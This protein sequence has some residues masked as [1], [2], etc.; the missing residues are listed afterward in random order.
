M[1]TESSQSSYRQ[2]LKATSIFG[3]VQVFNVIIGIIKSK[4]VA[5]LIGP[6]GMGIYGLYISTVDLIF[7]LTN[8]GLGVSAV[9]NVS[10]ANS[11]EDETKISKII[12]VLKRWIWLTGLVGTL[13]T[14]IFSKQISIFTFGNADFSLPICWLSSVFILKSL[15]SGQLAILQGMRKIEY[16]AKSS[17]LG[18]FIGLLITIPV[19]YYFGLKG[20]VPTI[21]FTAITSLL[22]TWYYSTK[23][24]ISK[25]K[26]SF[27]ETL[28]LGKEMISLGIVLSISGFITMG[29]AYF[30][31]IFIG[32]KGGIED[33]GLFQAGF[34][35]VD[36][37]VGMVFTAIAMD[38]YPQLTAVSADRTK[39][40]E[41]IDKQAT[42]TILI[43]APIVTLFLIFIPVIIKILLSEKFLEVTPYLQWAIL[44]ILIK[45]F[46]WP[47]GFILLAKGDFRVV[48]LKEL[49]V[50]IFF[51][52][53]SL[54]LYGL[55]GIE[56]LGISYLLLFLF[57]V[58]IVLI[59][60]KRKYDVTYKK[61]YIFF[62]TLLV[63][64]C[65]ISFLICRFTDPFWNYIAGSLVV[66]ITSYISLYKLNK[67]INIKQLISDRIRF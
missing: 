46:S 39:S 63:S 32:Q 61:S 66:F 59:I 26:I 22:F 7:S 29:V 36:S 52:T 64:L 12:I 30:I 19:Y 38:Y 55:Y 54:V 41:L 23:I 28:L 18:S 35:I 40:I 44:G 3:G 4:V 10:E 24:T 50:N 37:Y 67:L 57:N 2:I 11:T 20:I 62:F 5:I 15:S 49:C 45:G 58:V 9:R 13:L 21:I 25:L 17:V 6:L 65:V 47:I 16:L 56:G 51:L 60:S 34:S 27:R 43:L 1:T 48:F 14:I 31:K 8:L 53:S 42:I 33:V